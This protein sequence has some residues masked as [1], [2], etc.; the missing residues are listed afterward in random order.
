METRTPH[1]ISSS[2]V[3]L[4]PIKALLFSQAMHCPSPR[5][6]ALPSIHGAPLPP[7]MALP[8]PSTTAPPLPPSRTPLPLTPT[9]LSMAPTEGTNAND[10]HALLGASIYVEATL[11]L[12]DEQGFSR[13]YT[14]G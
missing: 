4:L 10:D 12:E 5:R 11:E 14:I 9:T 2:R 7:A 8:L 13:P 1:I 6:P 3:V